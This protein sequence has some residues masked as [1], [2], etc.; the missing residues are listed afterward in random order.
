MP[1]PL[2]SATPPSALCSVI[3]QSA[4]SVPGPSSDQA[5]GADAAVAVAERGDV[6]A[7]SS[8]PARVERDRTRKSLP[9]ACSLE[10]AGHAARRC[11]LQLARTRRA[12]SVADFAAV[13][14]PGDPRVAPEPHALAAGE[15]PGAARR[16]GRARRRATGIV[17]VEVGEHL[18]VADRLAGRCATA[19]RAAGERRGPRRPGRRRASRR[20]AASMRSR[21]HGARQ[22][23]ADDARPGT[24]AAPYSSRPGP[25]DENG[26]P[27]SSITSSARTMRRRLP[28]SMRAAAT[29]SSA[30]RARAYARRGPSA[31]RSRPR[32]RRAPRGPRPGTRGRRSTARTYRPV[33]PTSSARWPRASMSAIAARASAWNRADRPLLGG[34][35]TSIRWCGTAARSAGV[36]LAV[37]MSMPAVH[38]HRV[39]RDDLDVAER[40]RHVERE[41]RLARRGRADER[42]VR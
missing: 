31:S 30:L 6:A 34:S 2:I 7:S 9:V 23:D 3:V 33:P 15:L 40:S 42:E 1:L 13:A 12:A 14:E 20:T 22:P 29:G 25:N 36:G 41:R 32:A 4:P 17:A 8:A 21:Q 35:A 5:V 39:E 26:R 18:L 19:R 10:S 24:P 27:V 37:P 16:P 38:L 11:R 28:G